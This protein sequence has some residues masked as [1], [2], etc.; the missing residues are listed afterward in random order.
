MDQVGSNNLKKN[1]SAWAIFSLINNTKLGEKPVLGWRI[2][3]GKKVTVDVYIRVI[4][5]FRNELVIKALSPDGSKKLSNLIAGSDKLNL[6]LPDDL[7]LFQSRVLKSDT[8]GDVVI[9]IPNMIAHVDRR[10]HLRLFI[11]NDV[12][13]SIEFQKENHGQRITTQQFD[14]KCFDVSAGGLSFII[15]RIEGR[16]FEIGDRIYA[17][18]L[19]LDRRKT[20]VNAEVVNI[21]DVEPD[22]RNGLIYKGQKVC[23][24]YVEPSANQQS[25]INEFVFK[26]VQIHEAM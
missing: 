4:R 11:T 15:S 14:K 17:I 5:K 21:L 13:V 18:S 23:L 10:K 20:L 22:D 3:G 7:V 12:N 25:V 8:N 1:Y 9:S 6:Y 24:R 16:F 2:I 19:I 26:Y